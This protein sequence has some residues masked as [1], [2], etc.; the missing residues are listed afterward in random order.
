MS[1]KVT[2]MDLIKY[3]S[4]NTHKLNKGELVEVL[5]ILMKHVKDDRIV[6]KG[7]GTQITFDDIDTKA[8]KQVKA[9]MYDLIAK[10]QRE[11]DEL[12]KED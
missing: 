1:N 7:D 6:E 5:R 8:M 12:M 3:I 11:L 2:R 4:Q 10:K 9:F